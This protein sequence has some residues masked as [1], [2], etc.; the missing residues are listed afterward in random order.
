MESSRPGKLRSLITRAT[1]Q[2]AWTLEMTR[3]ECRLGGLGRDHKQ[4][5]L[6]VHCGW[7]ERRWK[8][9]RPGSL[10]EVICGAL[11]TN[12]GQKQQCWL[13]RQQEAGEQVRM[14]DLD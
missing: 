14:E 3:E 2:A 5:R 7:M 6:V 13:G 11:W 10:G 9:C 4:G 12:V 1:Q 8:W